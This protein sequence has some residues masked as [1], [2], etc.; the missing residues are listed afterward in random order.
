MSRRLLHA[1]GVAA[2]FLTAGPLSAPHAEPLPRPTAE[3]T[4]GVTPS[5]PTASSGTGGGAGAGAG[6]AGEATPSG[7]AGATA[8]APAG[9]TASPGAARTAPGPAATGAARGR[10]GGS[11]GDGTG[12]RSRT[13]DAGRADEATADVVTDDPTPTAEAAPSATPTASAGESPGTAAGAEVGPGTGSGARAGTG[14]GTGSRAGTGTGSK[15]GSGAVA[16]SGA[17]PGAGVGPGAGGGDGGGRSAGGASAS[18]SGGVDS[19]GGLVSR[20]QGLYRQAEEA[21]EAY[22]AAE[23]ALKV[24]QEEERRLGTDLGRARAALGVERAAAG[25]IA[26]EQYQGARGLSPYARMLLTGD[27]RA[28]QDQRRLAA[29]ESARQA[30]ILARL[31]RGER[32]ADVLATA[33][34]KALDAQQAGAARQKRLKDE[35]DLRLREVERMLSALSADELA[36]VGAREAADTASAQRELLASGRLGAP[37][38][39]RTRTPTE[40]GSTALAYATAQIGKPYVWGAEGPGAFDC[41]GLTSQAWAHAGRA[42]PRTSQEQWAQLPRVPLDRLRPGDLVVYFPTATHVALYVGDGKVIQAP[43][44]GAAVKVSPIAANPL[45]GAV[46]PDPDGVPLTAYNPPALLATAAA[47]ASASAP[48]GDAGYSSAEAPSAAGEEAS[49]EGPAAPSTSAR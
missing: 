49:A 39:A 18:R 22:N 12:R 10:G 31:A 42:I 34:R 45:L 21:A 13:G 38:A 32:R 29:R 25:R 47:A 16:G 36:R 43:R 20:L 27:L 11:A 23:A 2:L 14:T 5:A 41:S 35:A 48:G 26:R 7:T 3:A 46:R 44:P 37:A 30:G 17:S 4:A 33:A 6:A 15:T 24:R 19:V 8:T 1:A 28:A 9:A 40:A